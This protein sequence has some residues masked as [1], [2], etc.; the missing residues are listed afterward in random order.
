MKKFGSL[1]LKSFRRSFSDRSVWITI[2]YFE[3]VC[4]GGLI[5]GLGLPTTKA[6][7]AMAICISAY[8]VH[9][10]ATLAW[11]RSRQSH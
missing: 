8:Y 9:D 6:F 7:L 3:I 2:L 1:F 10:V 4:F 11:L 5:Y